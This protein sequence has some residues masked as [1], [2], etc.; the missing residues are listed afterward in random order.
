MRQHPALLLL[1]PLLRTR[2]GVGSARTLCTLCG[3]GFIGPVVIVHAASR[4]GAAAI[5]KRAAAAGTR[6]MT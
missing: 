3:E 4:R 6:D 2:G 1:L 5:G